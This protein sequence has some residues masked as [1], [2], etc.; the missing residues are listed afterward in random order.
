MAPGRGGQARRRS[1]VMSR[2]RRRTAGPATLTPGPGGPAR[3][4]RGAGT[5][6]SYPVPAAAHGRRV[7][8]AIIRRVLG[9][10]V[11]LLDVPVSL[12]G[13]AVAALQAASLEDG[14]AGASAHARPESVDADAA[15]GLRLVGSFRHSTFPMGDLRREAII[16]GGGVGQGGGE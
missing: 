10:P 9:F 5:C 8:A 6:G 15:S 11:D 7:R 4:G 2:A 1:S 16:P 12:D 14:A 3:G 13:E